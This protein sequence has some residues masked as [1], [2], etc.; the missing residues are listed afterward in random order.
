MHWNHANELVSMPIRVCGGSKKNLKIFPQKCW[1][2]MIF[3]A[4]FTSEGQK[5]AKL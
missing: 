5:M 1:V 4:T 3:L 2:F